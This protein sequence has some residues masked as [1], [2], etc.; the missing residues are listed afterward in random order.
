LR[1]V[2]RFSAA[3]VENCSNFIGFRWHLQLVC[4]AAAKHRLSTQHPQ[5]VLLLQQLQH[6]LSALA[7]AAGLSFNQLQHPLSA[8]ICGWLALSAI[9]RQLSA[10]SAAGLADGG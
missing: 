5:Q 8:L 2:W 4:F 9:G 6:P 1:G 7:S 10:A 3:L